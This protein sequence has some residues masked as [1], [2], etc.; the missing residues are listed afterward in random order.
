VT[1]AKGKPLATLTFEGA[2][3]ELKQPFRDRR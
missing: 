2:V 1:A 3:G